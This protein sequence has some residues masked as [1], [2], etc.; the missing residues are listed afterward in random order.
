V[1]PHSSL[2]KE[3]QENTPAMAEGLIDHRISY[4]ECIHMLVYE[5]YKW[6]EKISKKVAEM[7]EGKMLGASRRVKFRPEKA[8]VMQSREEAL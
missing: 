2:K 3:G 6:R 4:R 7:N 8:Q 5:D 1:I